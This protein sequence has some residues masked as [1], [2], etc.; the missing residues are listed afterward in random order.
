MSYVSRRV[1]ST[2][3]HLSRSTSLK[4]FAFYPSFFSESEQKILLSASLHKLDSTERR[5][6]R[7]RRK[8][9]LK[10]QATTNVSTSSIRDVFLP[11]NFYS[12]EEV[13]AT[14][15]VNCN[16]LLIRYRGSFWRRHP[17]V[18]GNACL[19][20]ARWISRN[21]LTHRAVKVSA[22]WW[23]YTNTCIALSV[24]RRDI[25]KSNKM[26][27]GQWADLGMLF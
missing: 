22:S 4:D 2:V 21:V 1:V 12:F 18:Q 14:N 3:T 7:R 16:A 13:F 25:G 8:E 26:S 5:E 15:N 17:P 24:G 20:V 19:R 10:Q 23:V 6:F 27:P 9:Y 11:D